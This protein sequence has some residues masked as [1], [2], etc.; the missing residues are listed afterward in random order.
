[1]CGLKMELANQACF[2]VASAL[3]G[4]RGVNLG[5]T[6]FPGESIRN[7]GYPGQQ[8]D[9]T[10]APVLRHNQKMHTEFKVCA[11]GDTPMDAAL[12]WVL[13]QLYFLPEPRK[14]ILLITDGLPSDLSATQKA[15]RAIQDFGMEIYGIGIATDALDRFLSGKQHRNITGMDELAPAMFGILQNALAGG[16]T[17]I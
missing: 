15:V 11:G 7:A 6:A 10:V 14:L 2:A 13:R 12:W 8:N 4:I 5:V 9:Q 17:A 3:H 16:H 1:M